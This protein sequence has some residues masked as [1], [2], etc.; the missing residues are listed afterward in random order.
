MALG[1]GLESLIPKMAVNEDEDNSLLTISIDR[2]KPN[3]D[4]PRT[5]FDEVKLQE[6]ADSILNRGIIEPIIVKPDDGNYVIIAGERRWRAANLA[7]L[8]EIPVIIN[9]DL[10]QQDI[11][12][13]ALIE[14]IQREDLN[15]IELARAYQILIENNHYTQDQLSEKLGVNRSSLTNTLRILKL[16]QEIQNMILKNELSFGAAK[17]LM[18]LNDKDLQLEIASKIKDNDLSVRETEKLIKSLK[19]PISNKKEESED[20]YL[21]DL[22]ETL[23]TKMDAQVKIKRTKKSGRI[24]ILFSSLDHLHAILS[25]IGIN[26]DLL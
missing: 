20:P 5:E 13:I 18:S 19:K 23:S 6:L 8:E 16:P 21:R 22:E 14:N 25:I 2:I 12:E 4:Q 1:R 15:I 3:K 26:E 7:G 17:A 10:N 24:E 11:L 9:N